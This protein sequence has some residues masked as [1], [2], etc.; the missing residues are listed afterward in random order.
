MKRKQKTSNSTVQDTS[1]TK[2]QH[3]KRKYH[4]RSVTRQNQEDTSPINVFTDALVVR[5]IFKYIELDFN[6]GERMN[7]MLVCK[8]W[9]QWVHCVDPVYTVFELMDHANEYDTDDHEDQ[10]Y[11]LWKHFFD[12]IVPAMDYYTEK[13]FVI[14]AMIHNHIDLI[15]MYSDAVEG[16]FDDDVYWGKMNTLAEEGNLDSVMALGRLPVKDFGYYHDPLATIAGYGT[17]EQLEE[18]LQHHRYTNSDRDIRIFICALEGAVSRGRVDN[19]RFLIEHEW[20]QLTRDN[21]R[22]DRPCEIIELNDRSNDEG[23]KTWRE[24]EDIFRKHHKKLTGICYYGR[25]SGP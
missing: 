15:E 10:I 8:T 14:W 9:A 4:T 11:W 19:V 7:Y 18:L 13:S 2:I 23:T 12:E 16:T 1:G 20:C 5:N 21:F 17:K 3:V 6:F 22:V 24:M 25:I